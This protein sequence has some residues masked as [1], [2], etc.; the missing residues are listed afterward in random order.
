MTQE[1]PL[2]LSEVQGP[3]ALVTLNRPKALNALSEELILRLLERL[4]GFDRD[5]QIRAM[6]VTGGRR[7]F[8]AGADIREMASATAEAM[9]SKDS[10]ARWDRFAKISKPLL[11]AVNGY[12]L[13]GGCELAMACDLIIAGEDAVFG[14][15]EIQLGIMP[16]A[17]ATQRLLEAVGKSRAL[18]MLWTGKRLSAAQALAWGLVNRV[19]PADR[20]VEEALRLAREVAAMPPA[21]AREIK[22]SVHAGLELGLAEGLRQER[23]RFYSLFGTPDQ[24]EGMAAFLEKRKPSF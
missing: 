16:G 7:V 24:K 14:Q 2:V 1:S 8:A 9:A 4:E 18:E 11:A 3:V 12:A 15:P 22:A 17:G 23:R 21:S 5:P 13:G 10:L 6:V 19:V 20:V